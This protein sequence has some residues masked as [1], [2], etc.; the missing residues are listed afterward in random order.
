MSLRIAHVIST[1]GMGGA[2]RFLATLVVSG[3]DRGL[4]QLVLNPFAVER[5]LELATLC[6]PVPYDSYPCDA[7]TELPAL[8]RWLTSRLAE[9]R[10][11]I[12]HVVL[13][14]ALLGSVVRKQPGAR[15][16]LTHV[17]G[18]GALS[19]VRGR[20][21]RLVDRAAA[22]RCDRVVAISQSVRRFLIAEYGRR[23]A[24]VTCIPLGWTGNPRPR[25]ARSRPPTV[26]CVAALRPEKGH[27]VLLQAFSRVRRTRPDAELVLIGDGVLRPRLEA[28]AS[29]SGDAA[30][31][32]FLGSVPDIWEH[33]ADADV[34]AIA[35]RSEAFGIAIAEAMAAGLPVVAP[36][37]GAIAELVEP[38][39]TGELFSPGDV[40]AMARHLARLLTS[41]D[42][43]ASMS[44]AALAAAERLRVENAVERYFDVYDELLASSH[45][46]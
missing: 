5:S 2:E 20:V 17:Y 22:R 1:R 9:F 25:N 30:H 40:E 8:H 3:H 11:D 42:V 24:E 23:E 26:V 19:G 15:Y 45:L 28:Q 27:D 46:G 21:T 41:P 32:R 18:E 16:L 33:L 36:A 44:R 31:I 13:F 12:I 7:M 38:G 34:F 6:H 14:H 43:R 37:V 39:V 10:P 29:A 35:S 4:D